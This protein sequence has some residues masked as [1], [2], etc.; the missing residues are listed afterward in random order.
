MSQLLLSDDDVALL[1]WTCELFFVPESPL[2]RIDA[3]AREPRD[4]AVTYQELIRKGVLDDATFRLTDSALNRMAPLSECDARVVVSLPG[5]RG[6]KPRVKDHYLLDEIAV[7]YE[8]ADGLHGVGPDSDHQELVGGLIKRFAPR[9][10]SGDYLNFKLTPQEFMVFCVLAHRARKNQGAVNKDALLSE[11]RPAI[12]PATV[13]A[14]GGVRRR[15]RDGA[16][17]LEDAAVRH[18]AAQL[19]AQAAQEPSPAQDVG[20]RN[21][22][23]VHEA[24]TAVLR[25]RTAATARIA[26][27]NAFGPDDADTAVAL[28]NPRRTTAAAPRPVAAEAAEG[29]DAAAAALA[30]LVQKGVA[31]AG[32]KGVELRPSVHTMAA[33]LAEKQRCSV[34][35]FDF[36]DD[37]WFV[38]ETSFLATDGSLFHL[39]T[40]DA[41]LLWVMELDQRRLETAL[42]RAVGPLPDAEEMAGKSA[43]DFLLRA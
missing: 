16:G 13:E 3:E 1:R 33:N 12:T 5:E 43:K 42:L 31:L 34:V 21:T 26:A 18:R 11:V 19:M 39:G 10:A 37:E 29:A 15:V 22:A 27:A 24:N 25:P 41:G 17:G 7:E 4:F 30:G 8:W 20:A 28:R 9:K 14:L 35:R 2:H 6:A 36:S 38:R 40:D 32:P 23:A